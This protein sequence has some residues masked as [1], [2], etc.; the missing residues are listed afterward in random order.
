M[1]HNSAIIYPYC[2][3][4]EYAHAIADDYLKA[5]PEFKIPEKNENNSYKL[6]Y[7]LLAELDKFC[8]ERCTYYEYDQD[9]TEE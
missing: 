1:R 2:T 5:H 3:D 9:Y 4:P 8:D 6:S 7:E